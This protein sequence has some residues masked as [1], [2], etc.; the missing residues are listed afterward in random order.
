MTIA[1]SK[2]LMLF[3]ITANSVSE[4]GPTESVHGV[5]GVLGR[6]EAASDEADV[7]ARRQRSLQVPLLSPSVALE[8]IVN[9][10]AVTMRS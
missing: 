1:Y 5:A 10:L 4:G 8:Y 9:K 3:L 2:M 7:F 6:N